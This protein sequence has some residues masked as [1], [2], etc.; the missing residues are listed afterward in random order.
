[1]RNFQSLSLGKR[2]LVAC[3]VA[4]LILALMVGFYGLGQIV[5][6][7]ANSLA[8]ASSPTQATMTMP[9]STASLSPTATPSPTAMPS[10]TASPS[11]TAQPSPAILTVTPRT[12][13]FKNCTLSGRA[14][15]YCTF[16]LR[17]AS[18]TS[19]LAWRA[20]ASN[21]HGVNATKYLSA[22]SGT[23]PK[24]GTTTVSLFLAGETGVCTLVGTTV[25]L[26]FTGPKNTVTVTVTC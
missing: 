16:T 12:Y 9:P 18:S 6:A 25:Y 23:L 17:N 2:S 26:Q 15:Y 24:K 7:P 5:F 11:P 1:M 8:G 20:K 21:S 14:S 13:Y 10:P 22:T 19:P 4:L 3:L